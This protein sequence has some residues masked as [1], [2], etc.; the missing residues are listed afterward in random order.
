[1][2]RKLSLA[3]TLVVGGATAALAQD[4]SEPLSSALAQRRLE[5]YVAT[6]SANAGI[7]A[8]TVGNYYADRSIYYGKPMS[9]TQ[10][11]RDKLN[12]VATWPE[13]HYRIVPGTVAAACDHAKTMCRVSGIMQWDRRS[14][15]GARSLGSAR[16]SLTL[17]RASGGKIVHESA[18]ILRY[19]GDY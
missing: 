7:N 16:I 1:M 11:L 8:A 17:S 18:S 12:Y 9:R 14:R 4:A 13:R 3:A 15:G 6:W 10:I 19:A 5:A 2:I